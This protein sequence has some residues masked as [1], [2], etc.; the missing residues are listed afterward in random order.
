VSQKHRCP[1]IICA[2]SLTESPAPLN[3]SPAFQLLGGSLWPPNPW[4]IADSTSQ[5]LRRSRGGHAAHLQTGAHS[6]AQLSSGFARSVARS[7]TADIAGTDEGHRSFV[8]RHTFNRS[9][10]S[11]FASATARIQV[12]A[13]LEL[14]PNRAM[15]GVYFRERQ[16]TASEIIF[17]DSG[18]FQMKTLLCSGNISC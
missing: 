8:N 18:C 14:R 16:L 3:T 6:S 4:R 1:Q 17:R 10:S 7:K 12:C 11:G 2:P 15:L 5:L 9:P 13:S